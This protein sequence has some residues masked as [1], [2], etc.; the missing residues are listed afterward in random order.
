MKNQ[1]Y[2]E[3]SFPGKLRLHVA[4]RSGARIAVGVIGLAVLTVTVGVAA[5]AAQ[6]A[7]G[8]LQ[9]SGRT[10][11]G[12]AALPEVANPHPDANRFLE[13]SMQQRD[14]MKRIMELNELRQKEMTSDTLRLVALAN[15]LKTE[16]D[17]GQEGALYVDEVRKVEEI[18]KL[19]HGVQVKMRTTVSN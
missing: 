10:S 16:V 13:D 15:A 1:A 4:Q 12:F 18:E 2:R 3:A 19:A 5:L 14:V 17:K 7:S 8:T 11:E 6:Q 9:S